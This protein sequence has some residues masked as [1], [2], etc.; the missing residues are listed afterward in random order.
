MSN[1]YGKG[2]KGKATKLH[3]QLTRSLGYCQCCG[4][5]NHLQCAHIISRKYSHTRTDLENAFC[6]CAACHRYFTDNPVEFGDFV[7][8]EIGDD[9]YV[10]LKKQRESLDKV[11]WTEE[12]ARLTSIAKERDIV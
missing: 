8:R 7:T 10:A 2:D 9:K 12:V 11:D 6:L 4:G 1:I 5:T 3:A